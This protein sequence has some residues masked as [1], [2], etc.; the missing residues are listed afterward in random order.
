MSDGLYIPVAVSVAVWMKALL[1][2]D[3]YVAGFTPPA[4][5]FGSCGFEYEDLACTDCPALDECLELMDRER[6]EK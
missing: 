2:R 5:Y 4:P 6:A 3:G 1:D